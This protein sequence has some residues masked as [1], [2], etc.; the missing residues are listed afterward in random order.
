MGSAAD[1][2]I[3]GAG[4][5]GSLAALVLARAGAKVQL[6]DRATFPRAK[7]CGDTINPGAVAV[8]RRLGLAERI[9]RHGLPVDGMVLTGLCGV[10]VTSSYGR[11]GTMPRG[12]AMSRRVLDAELVAAA[13]DA[14][15]RFDEGVVVRGPIVH[16]DGTVL[17]F[18]G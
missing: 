7:L 1:V 17:G 8:L 2:V 10:V 5:A 9:Q 14:G 15:V 18:V 3:A 13:V 16:D 6:L 4:P 12:W 11:N